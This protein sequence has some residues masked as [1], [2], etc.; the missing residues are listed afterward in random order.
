[1]MQDVIDVDEADENED[2]THQK[3]LDGTLKVPSLVE[4]RSEVNKDDSPEWI[5][6]D[7]E[8]EY[9]PGAWLPTDMGDATELDQ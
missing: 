3:G 9:E 6:D 8:D 4:A 2:L 5:D 7:D 1:M